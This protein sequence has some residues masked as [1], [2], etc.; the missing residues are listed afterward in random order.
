MRLAL[1]SIVFVAIAGDGATADLPGGMPGTAEE[2][3]RHDPSL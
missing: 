1:Q 2:G 3:K